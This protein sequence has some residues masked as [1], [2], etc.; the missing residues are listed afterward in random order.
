MKV[1]TVVKSLKQ[2]RRARAREAAHAPRPTPISA[3]PQVMR[4]WSLLLPP[5]TGR[6]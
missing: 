1:A 6:R 2:T 4:V 3:Q 5:E